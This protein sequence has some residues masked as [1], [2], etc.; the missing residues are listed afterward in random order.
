MYL[1]SLPLEALR[2]R[3]CEPGQYVLVEDQRV[4]ACSPEAA[5]AGV[6]IGMRQ[7]GASTVAP[8]ATILDRAVARERM[9]L[10]AIALALLQFTPELA[11]IGDTTMILDVTASLRLFD[12]HAALCRRVRAVVHALGFS[13]NLGTGPTAMGAWMLSVARIPARRSRRRRAI[14]P[15]T[16]NALLDPLDCRLLPSAAR[17]SSSMSVDLGHP[18]FGIS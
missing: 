11:Q 10:D 1:P 16:L 9:A 7:G 5:A 18:R 12:G 6:S 2:P 8:G 13:I 3:W 17:F 14:K 4:V 15:S